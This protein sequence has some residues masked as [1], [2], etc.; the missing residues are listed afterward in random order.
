[1]RAVVSILLLITFGI[2]ISVSFLLGR[3]TA[4]SPRVVEARLPDAVTVKNFE[5][6]SNN[7]LGGPEKDCA[8]AIID[9]EYNEAAL[10]I[11]ASETAAS[12]RE[13]RSNFENGLP[14]SENSV[15]GG[16]LANVFPWL[17]S[18]FYVFSNTSMFAV[19][20]EI[21][22]LLHP[23]YG[24]SLTSMF[25][26]PVACTPRRSD[27][28]PHEYIWNLYNRDVEYVFLD[29]SREGYVMAIISDGKLYYFEA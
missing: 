22:V 7:A 1:M 11:E 10:D 27:V 6:F 5:W 12:Y 24:H 4:N 9:V 13:W 14:V 23:Y 28:S 18:Q 8:F 16:V 20:D 17:P 2:G 3:Q 25:Q 15:K 29:I 21:A 19:F 26:Q